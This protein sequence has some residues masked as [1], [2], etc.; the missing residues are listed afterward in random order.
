MVETIQKVQLVQ[1]DF[2]G[3]EASDVVTSLIDTKINFHKFQNLCTYEGQHV[4]GDTSYCDGRIAELKEE[5]QMAKDYIKIARLSGK[6][7][8]IEGTL[9]ITILDD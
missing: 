2:T 4:D 3:S 6:K 7:V 8:R 5:R 9:E 1:G